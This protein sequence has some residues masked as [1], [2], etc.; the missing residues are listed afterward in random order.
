M[1]CSE[2]ELLTACKNQPGQNILHGSFIKDHLGNCV[3]R[4][5]WFLPFLYQLRYHRHLLGKALTDKLMNEFVDGP[6]RHTC[7]GLP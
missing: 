1:V 5:N 2:V 3:V 4:V 7:H 6:L